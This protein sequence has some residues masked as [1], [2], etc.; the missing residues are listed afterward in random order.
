[1]T[2]LE[3]PHPGVTSL[4]STAP[5]QKTRVCHLSVGLRTGGLERLLVDFA[6]FRDSSRFELTFVALDRIGRPAEEIREFGCE[7]LVIPDFGASWKQFKSMWSLFRER[8]FD[9]LHT[10]NAHPHFWGTCAA[11]TA[12]VPV[13][14]TTRHGQRFGQSLSGRVKFWLAGQLADRVVTVSE[15]AARLSMVED[16]IAKRKI[17]TIWNGI[18]PQKFQYRGPCDEPRCISV[19]RLSPEKDF[20]TLL[21]AVSL[22]R[23]EIPGLR[24][25]LVGDGPERA[26]LESLAEQLDL[27][28][29][30]DFL[31]ERND[32]PELL[33]NS[34]FF[35][36]S[37][38]TEGI[39]LTLLEAMAV[40]LP[41]LATAVGGNPEVVVQ[42]ET[43]LLVDSRDPEQLSEG[44]VRM[45]NRRKEW[46]RMG[47]FGRR[48]VEQHFDVRRM[49]ANYEEE[50][51]RNLNAAHGRKGVTTCTE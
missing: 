36:S 25:S 34:G 44:I 17:R 35:V 28:R 26:Q 32:I 46:K 27:C 39:S 49:V 5:A 18:D 48:R 2:T 29:S 30:V 8:N 51:L 7:V 4:L 23:R 47:Q 6:R 14:L 24:L 3:A 37:S 33:A 40:G 12:G 9:V 20:P 1:M 43:G 19:A 21:K 45:W 13:T 31:G 16:R 10:H 42:E 38:L 41:V 22:A 11:W 15:D 50:Y